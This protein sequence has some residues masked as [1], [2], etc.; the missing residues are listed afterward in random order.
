MVGGSHLCNG[1]LLSTYLEHFLDAGRVDGTILA[2]VS[3]E[4]VVRIFGHLAFL[5]GLV[6]TQLL[7]DRLRHVRVQIVDE[8]VL[9]HC[10][11]GLGI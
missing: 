2:Q 11:I 9:R 8:D 7:E 6:V 4:D 10:W 3:S 5:V 1:L